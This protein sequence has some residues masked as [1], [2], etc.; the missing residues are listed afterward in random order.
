MC[1][2]TYIPVKSGILLTSNRDEQV[3]RESSAPP[4]MH[5][6]QNGRMLF[7]KDGKAGGT[8]I[9][10]HENGNAMVLLNGAF[11]KHIPQ[12]PYR[13]S[14]G[15]IFLEVFNYPRPEKSFETIDLN[16]IEPFTLVIFSHDRLFEAMWDGANKYMKTLDAAKPHIWSSTTLYDKEATL[17]RESWFD[18]W[19]RKNAVP[20]A[21]DIIGFHETAGS[22]D[23]KISI[24]M[25]RD[26]VLKTVSITCIK[27]GLS[28]SSM[29]YRD[30]RS[31]LKSA[32]EW[33]SK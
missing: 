19:L 26:G 21:D 18:A 6:F 30:L 10:L 20:D 11:Q 14:R 13:E 5:E 25:N 33:Y 1:T 22:G 27:I 23:P 3:N 2:V 17:L 29:Y 31:G 7:P 24:N 15:L 9:A 4:D 16:N 12:P 32:V 8:W 28:A